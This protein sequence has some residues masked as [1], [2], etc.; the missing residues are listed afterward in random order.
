MEEA[1]KGWRPFNRKRHSGT[2]EMEIKGVIMAFNQGFVFRGNLL[3]SRSRRSTIFHLSRAFPSSLI[4]NLL[5]SYF[6]SVFAFS[7]M[8]PTSLVLTAV[9]NIHLLVRLSLCR[10]L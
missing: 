2:A 1:S 5:Q 4:S 7:Q 3:V 9:L 6:I 8:F 10:I